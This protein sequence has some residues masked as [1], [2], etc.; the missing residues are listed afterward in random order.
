MSKYGYGTDWEGVGMFVI[1]LI[2]VL[3]IFGGMGYAIVSETN[4][5]NKRSEQCIDAGKD[6]IDGNC[7][8]VGRVDVDKD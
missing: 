1:I 6:W 4:A 5:D 3:A 8:T 7:V 2:V